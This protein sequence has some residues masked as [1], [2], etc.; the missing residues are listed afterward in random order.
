MFLIFQF[1][2][3]YANRIIRFHIVSPIYSAIWFGII[4]LIQK[5]KIINIIKKIIVHY[6]KNIVISYESLKINKKNKF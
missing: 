2:L 3:S 1:S 4:A 5:G 6:V